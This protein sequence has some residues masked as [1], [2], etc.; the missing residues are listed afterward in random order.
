MRDALA[1]FL[2]RLATDDDYA[3]RYLADRESVLVEAGLN[4]ETRAALQARDATLDAN[5][6]PS[7][8]QATV[9]SSDLRTA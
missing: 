7:T 9:E 1:D 4:G 8:M 6:L 3:Q 2:A 5:P